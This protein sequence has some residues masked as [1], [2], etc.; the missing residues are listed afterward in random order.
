MVFPAGLCVDR[1]SACGHRARTG[2]Y[3]VGASHWDLV[4]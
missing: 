2:E 3:E 1:R 4:Q